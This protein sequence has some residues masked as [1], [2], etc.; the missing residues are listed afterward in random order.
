MRYHYKCK[1]GYV[2]TMETDGTAPASIKCS[3]CKDMIEK[4]IIL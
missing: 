1:C 2:I 3:V 4:E